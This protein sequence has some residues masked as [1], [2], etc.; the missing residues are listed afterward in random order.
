MAGASAQDVTGSRQFDQLNINYTI[1]GGQAL[2]TV[3]LSLSGVVVD[4]AVLSYEAPVY[5]F[6]IAAGGARAEGSIGLAVAQAPRLSGIEG[7]FTAWNRAAKTTRFDGKI[8]SWI[9]PDSLVLVER[10]FWLT[11]LL[12]AR[13]TVRINSRSG[14]QV[15]I[16]SGS[17]V[18]FS[19]LLLPPSPVAVTPVDLIVGNVKVTRGAKMTL[20]PPSSLAAGTMFLEC[21]FQ[22]D[23]TPSTAFSGMV[24]TWAQDTTVM[25]T[26]AVSNIGSQ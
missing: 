3:V 10:N 15:D 12:N 5:T 26:P 14:A 16:L 1:A 8:A 2:A 20:T 17:V 25:S 22:T 6:N 24:A 4:K 13:T 7:H 11:G 9:S 18:L 23:T 19:T 21:Q